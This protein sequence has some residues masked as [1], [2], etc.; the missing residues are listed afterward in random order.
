[1]PTSAVPMASVPASSRPLGS[2]R[3]R[4]FIQKKKRYQRGP[5]ASLLDKLRTTVS[6]WGPGL[7]VLGAE[8]RTLEGRLREVLVGIL[9]TRKEV[10][11]SL[12]TQE[13]LLKKNDCKD[14]NQN[15]NTFLAFGVPSC[16]PPL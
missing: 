9:V 7:L 11:H 1:M 8:E 3:L 16:V 6:V 14:G 4:T 13:H 12:H 10:S 5:W 15:G 2:G